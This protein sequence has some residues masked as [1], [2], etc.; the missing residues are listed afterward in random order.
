[1]NFLRVKIILLFESGLQ[2]RFRRNFVRRREPC[3]QFKFFL[4][5]SPDFKLFTQH[6][7]LLNEL[8]LLHRSLGKFKY[9]F[10]IDIY[11]LGII[12]YQLWVRLFI[13]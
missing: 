12:M 3:L 10:V 9:Q 7:D 13:S 2:E 1:M 5:N 4:F 11:L 8:L 6:D